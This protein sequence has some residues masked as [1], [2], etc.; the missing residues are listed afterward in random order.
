MPR[1]QTF[2]G[3]VENGQIRLRDN[4]TLPDKVRVYV[5]VPEMLSERPARAWS[6]RLAH[7]EQAKEFIKVVLEE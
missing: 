7:P 2:E 4:V 5:I 1:V 6:P 3:T